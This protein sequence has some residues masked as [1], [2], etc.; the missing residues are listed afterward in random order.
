[1]LFT[2]RHS[3]K[4]YTIQPYRWTLLSNC[5][6]T[7]I[8]IIGAG[9]QV[10]QLACSPPPPPPRVRWTQLGESATWWGGGGGGQR[11]EFLIKV[12]DT[13]SLLQGL[14]NR[15]VTKYLKLC[16]VLRTFSLIWGQCY[17]WNKIYKYVFRWRKLPFCYLVGIFRRGYSSVYSTC[18]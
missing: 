12:L 15:K 9:I 11:L 4:G 17:S 6:G 8:H 18:F 13:S 10:S 5:T 1:M 2:K 3:W 14:G 16:N 7:Y